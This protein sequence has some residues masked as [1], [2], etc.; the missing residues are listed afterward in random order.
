MKNKLY[1]VLD[2]R[3]WLIQ[4]LMVTSYVVF[5]WHHSEN[6]PLAVAAAFVLASSVF[7]AGFL[8]LEKTERSHAKDS[9]RLLDQRDS[10][11]PHWDGLVRYT[12]D[13]EPRLRLLQARIAQD[14]YEV[15]RLLAEKDQLTGT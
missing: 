14:Q 3:K 1:T 13:I 2:K 4:V 8:I 11:S 5:L 9:Q 6:S 10:S 15:N 7:A 12:D